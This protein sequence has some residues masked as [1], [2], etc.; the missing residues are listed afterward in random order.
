[1]RLMLDQNVAQGVAAVFIANGHEVLYARDLLQ[2][3]SPDPLLAVAAA[4]E[5]LI[6]VTHDRDFRRYRELF[7]QG[8]RTQARHATGRIVLMIDEAKA[9]ARVADVIE[10]IE[11]QH[12]FAV[13]RGIRFMLTV[14]ATNVSLT[15]NAR[16]P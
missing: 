10:L 11:L 1:M 6:V 5:G 2:Q 12:A 7:P 15:D 3:D 14:T 9:A 13:R 4:L 8:F 16:T